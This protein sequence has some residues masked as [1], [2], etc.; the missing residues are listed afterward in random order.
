MKFSDLVIACF[1]LV[2]CVHIGHCKKC[3]YFIILI[4]PLGCANVILEHFKKC[5]DAMFEME[6]AKSS[7]DCDQDYINTV[8]I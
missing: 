3:S 8:G 4:L 1:S 5:L 6:S 7:Y 2:D